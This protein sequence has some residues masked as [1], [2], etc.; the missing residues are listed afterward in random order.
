MRGPGNGKRAPGNGALA[1]PVDHGRPPE[2]WAPPEFPDLS[3]EPVLRADFETNGLKWWAGHRPCGLAVWAPKRG[4]G[5]YFPTDHLGGGNLPR[6]R[7]IAW[8]T[9]PQ[10]LRGKRVTNLNTRF[11]THMSINWGPGCDWREVCRELGD[12]G[13][14]A[15]LLDDWR[16][17]FSL[18]AVAR[19]ALGPGRQ[20]VELPAG[21]AIHELPGWVVEPYAIEDV[22]LVQDISVVQSKLLRHMNLTRVRQLEDAM[23]P[24]TVEMEQN[25]SLLDWEKLARWETETEQALL[26]VQWDLYKLT[27]LKVEPTKPASCHALLKHCGIESP[28]DPETGQ[29]TAAVALLK[30]MAAREEVRLLIRGMQ[31]ASLRSKYLV[32]YGDQRRVYGEGPLRYA[33]HQL[34][35]D[36]GGTITGR[37]SSSALD[38]RANPKYGVNVQQVTSAGKQKKAL[39]DQWVIRELFVPAPGRVYVGADAMQIQY[40]LFADMAQNPDVIARY[41]AD[42]RGTD[43]HATVQEMAV[44]LMPSIRALV[45]AG[46]VDQARKE[47]KNTNFALMFGAGVRKVGAMN[48]M[49]YEAAQ[50]F[51][52]SYKRAFP[53]VGRTIDRYMRQAETWGEVRT[54]LGRRTSFPGKERLHKALNAVIQGDEADIVKQTEVDLYA[55][56]KRLGL[57]MRVSNHDEFGGDLE[58]PGMLSE[59]MAVLERPRIETSVPITWSGG[60]GANWREAK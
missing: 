38:S 34:R 60:T 32:K 29:P 7:V 59:L 18:N 57:T 47:V 5:Y 20:K 44:A 39:G 10:G 4:R 3:D 11:D 2:G 27:G 41:Q 13:H 19:D 56:R 24:V 22:R 28:K 36:E 14:Y 26:R 8:M 6:E 43:Y 16:R 54:R 52:S 21:H 23:I 48:G 51:V 40:R 49:E 33:L 42:P 50:V 15:A 46:N 9:S 17:E 25:G 53:E 12:V 45:E 55:E 1:F 37:R 58:D 31:I 30:P 35:T